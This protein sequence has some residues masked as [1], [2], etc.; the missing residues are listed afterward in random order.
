M[1]G[2][3]RP[4]VIDETLGRID[5]M[6]DRWLPVLI[7]AVSVHVTF[8]DEGSL[9]WWEVKLVQDACYQTG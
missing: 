5:R 3:Y 4:N 1:C 9:T 7:R 2:T 8:P 6:F